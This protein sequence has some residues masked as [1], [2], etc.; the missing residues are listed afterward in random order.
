MARFL[1]GFG[2]LSLLTVA[3]GCAIAAA[4]GVG[5]GSWA[6]N[7]V[8]WAV[9]AAAAL[10]VA[11]RPAILPGFLPAAAVALA[12]TLLNAPVDGVHRWIDVGPLHINA[13]AALLPAAIVAL[14]VMQRPALELARGGRHPRPARGAA[15]CVPGDGVRRGDDRRARVAP[16]A[17]GGPG[18]RGGR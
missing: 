13:A 2:L 12:V 1:A 4:H 10:V 16:R 14:A 3:I 8:A 11:R 9:G 5:A 15:G 18:G 6:R 17:G 7:L